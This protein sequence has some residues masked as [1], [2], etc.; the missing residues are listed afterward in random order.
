M[1]TN[2]LCRMS[3]SQE[4]KQL[5]TDFMT[6]IS[7][8]METIDTISNEIPE[9][10]YLE[11]M[12]NLKD[13]YGFK[14]NI[15]NQEQ[16]NQVLRVVVM[17]NPVVQ[18]ERRR[19]RMKVIEPRTLKTDAQKLSS[20]KYVRCPLCDTIISKP[21]LEE[22]KTTYKCKSFNKSKKITA[23]VGR[24]DTSEI[25]TLITKI[26]VALNNNGSSINPSGKS[27]KRNIIRAINKYYEKKSKMYELD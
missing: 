5:S 18:R 2:Y 15:S 1:N 6:I 7:S 9:G 22:H 12:N 23:N 21:Q 4:N 16:F 8:L 17:E 20:G 26:Q 27:P 13:L 3:I 24:E 14:S 19:S 11:I 10:K 25:H